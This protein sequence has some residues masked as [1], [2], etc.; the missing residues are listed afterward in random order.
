M[1]APVE[2]VMNYLVSLRREFHIKLSDNHFLKDSAPVI[3]DST[4]CDSFAIV[5]L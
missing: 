3:F 4:Q 5:G 1:A 2:A